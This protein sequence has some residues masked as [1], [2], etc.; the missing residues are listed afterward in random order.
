MSGRA[1]LDKGAA[2]ERFCCSFY[3]RC[4]AY[5][6]VPVSPSSICEMDYHLLDVYKRMPPSEF[7]NE[8]NNYVLCHHKVITKLLKSLLFAKGYSLSLN[9]LHFN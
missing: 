5:I 1:S 6:R 9:Q 7:D 3:K 4:K 8:N 2:S